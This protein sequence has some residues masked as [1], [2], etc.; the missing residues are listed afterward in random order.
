MREERSFG[1]VMAAAFAIFGVYPLRAGLP[2]RV[3][4]LAVAVG[5]LLA[6]W[7]APRLLGPLNRAWR[8][9]GILM[10]KVVHPVVLAILFYGVFTPMGLAMRL[11][12]RDPMRRKFDPAADSYW[13][14]RQP[15]GPGS[16]RD[17]F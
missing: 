7:A 16:M 14:P 4:A 8:Q 3:W 13:L 2:M 6:G 9:L 1:F 11:A 5:F 15:P 12:G 10:G 17:P